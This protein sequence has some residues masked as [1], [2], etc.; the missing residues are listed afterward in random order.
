MYLVKIA[1]AALALAAAATGALAETRVGTTVE[2]RLL[3]GFRSPEP[4]VQA[5]LPQGWNLVTL[6]Q[7]PLAGTNMIL[8][9]LD[10]HL[11]LDA[12][13]KP[14]TAS[15]SPTAAIFVYGRK[16]GVDAP[17]GFI[18]TTWEEPPAS[19]PYKTTTLADIARVSTFTDEGGGTRS[20]AETWTIR[21]ETGG[22]IAVSLEAAVGPMAW[23]TDQVSRPYSATDP[24]FSRIY[25]YD[26]LVAPLMSAAA[27]RPLKGTASVTT[28]GAGLDA[29]FDGSEELVSVLWIPVYA[30]EISLP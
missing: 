15:S 26:Q 16:E 20:L 9:M 21:P 23:A 6:P 25:R 19:D 28:A 11:M 22:E 4:A 13:G 10:R 30:R 24:E 7:G 12:E 8:L 29:L 1:A 3:L 5:L 14:D 18:V 2:S 17:R 27:G